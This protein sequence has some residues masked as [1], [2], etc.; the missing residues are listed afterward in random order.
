VKDD[1][2]L[3]EE[4]RSGN[5]ASFGQLVCRYQDRLYN[6]LV[7]VLGCRDEAEDV[8]QETFVQAYTKLASFKGQ[9]AF[10]TW[11]YR[12]GVNMSVS[13]RRRNRR[14]VSLESADRT[15][16]HEPAD[17][18]DGPE[19]QLQRRERAEQ[20]RAALAELSPEHRAILVLREVEGCGYDMIS[21]ILDLP[22]GT[23]RSRLH[24]ARTQ[25]RDRLKR[26]LQEQ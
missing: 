4:A 8:A 17:A 16:G 2:L 24:R 25:L 20:V 19:Q 14:H 15:P 6:T 11:L 3:I 5:T 23:V 26:V 1:A 12:I 22:I 10:Y 7:H 18:G 9:S 21:D 13:R